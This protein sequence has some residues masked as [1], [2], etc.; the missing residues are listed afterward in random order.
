MVTV[1]VVKEASR[2][3]GRAWVACG[4]GGRHLTSPLHTSPIGAVGGVLV[5]GGL[6]VIWVLGGGEASGRVEA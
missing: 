2:K 4:R 3:G 1:V 6:E 5:G